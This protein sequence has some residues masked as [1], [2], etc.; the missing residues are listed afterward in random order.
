MQSEVSRA[1]D[2]EDSTCCVY[3]AL[4]R[5]LL[6]YEDYIGSS[7][8]RTDCVLGNA[9]EALGVA[10]CVRVR[11]VSVHQDVLLGV[12]F[13][14]RVCVCVCVLVCVWV[15]GWVGGGGPKA[16]SS[17]LDQP[18]SCANTRGETAVPVVSSVLNSTISHAHDAWS[19]SKSDEK[20]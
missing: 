12:G 1:V 9:A 14:V 20:R 11:T 6:C 18:L 19:T 4:D 3:V 15:G 2:A 17:G 10:C 8:G 5:P 7:A 16:V 13:L